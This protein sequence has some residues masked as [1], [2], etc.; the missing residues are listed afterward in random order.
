MTTV[1]FSTAVVLPNIFG[2]PS[3][4]DTLTIIQA[5]R[6]TYYEPM[7]LPLGVDELHY[8]K[9][10]VWGGECMQLLTYDRGAPVYFLRFP[11]SWELKTSPKN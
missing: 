5:L 1:G 11:K 4:T 8:V 2:T 6:Y 7:G 3:Y 9:A 10:E